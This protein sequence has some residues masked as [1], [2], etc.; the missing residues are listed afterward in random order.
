MAARFRP[1]RFC[2]LGQKK[3]GDLTQRTQ[4]K[5]AEFAEKSDAGAHGDRSDFGEAWW[6]PRSLRSA[7][8]KGV[9]APVG[10]TVN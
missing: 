7:A 4:R 1:C 5:S 6:L 3:G 9:A 10:M 8:T 2:L